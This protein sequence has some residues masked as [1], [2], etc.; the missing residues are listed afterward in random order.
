MPILPPSTSFGPT[1]GRPPSAKST[2]A[3]V[4][5]YDDGDYIYSGYALTDPLF[6]TWFH[7][8][9]I[10]QII[11]KVTSRLLNN[12]YFAS[13][14]TLYQLPYYFPLVCTYAKYLVGQPYAHSSRN[15]DPIQDVT[16]ADALAYFSENA[17]AELKVHHYPFHVQII[18]KVTTTFRKPLYRVFNYSQNPLDLVP[19]PITL[20]QETKP[21]LYGVELELSTDYTTQELVDAAKDPFFIL[22]SDRTVSGNR[23]N[24]YELCSIPM[25]YKAHRQQW[26]H[27]FKNLDYDKFDQT[28][29][30][31]NGL[32]VHISKNAFSKAHLRNF[33]WFFT[34]PG[35]HRFIL[36]ISERDTESFRA[37]SQTPN[38]PK[39]PTKSYL[40]TLDYVARIRG[41]VNISSKMTIEL[42]LFRG[43]VSLAEILKNLEFVDSVYHFTKDAAYS[44]LSLAN[45]N[46]WLQ[47]TPPNR[48]TL[49][50]KYL[51]K[52]P[53]LNACFAAADIH[54]IIHTS[55]DANEI[56][57]LLEKSKL[58]ITNVHVTI[59]NQLFKR[60][61]FILNKLT[62]QIELSRHNHG[63]LAHLDRSLEQRLL[64]NTS[65]TIVAPPIPVPDAPAPPAGVNTRRSRPMFR[66]D[67]F[68][69]D[70]LV[71]P[72]PV[73]ALADPY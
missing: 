67:R 72:T 32:H 69:L 5:L 31:T 61:T 22:K 37:Y 70:D 58:P 6:S 33:A 73:P 16:T 43:I 66:L 53:D 2:H 28:K 14:R 15:G 3:P 11:S 18:L 71:A 8:S 1:T 26:A 35:H 30:T 34:Q 51:D 24:P 68:N 25:S 10:N 13:S 65:P 20:P 40:Q 12:I 23:K 17:T 54:R 46:Q 57:Q 55:N 50:K 21:L 7:E 27:W 4:A 56:L 39:D 36:A 19:W 60:R 44:A 41:C 63:K 42:R 59:L 9:V 49:I 45:Y 47:K 64:R 38:Y 62:G 52:L 48:Y 29:D